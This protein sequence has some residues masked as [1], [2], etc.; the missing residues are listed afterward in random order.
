MISQ[1]GPEFE[2]LS[3]AGSPLSAGQLKFHPEARLRKHQKRLQRGQ[4]EQ[5]DGEEQECQEG[6]PGIHELSAAKA[7]HMGASPTDP[8]TLH[9]AALTGHSGIPTRKKRT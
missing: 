7:S 8:K 2:T 1:G 4:K 6:W 9:K 3:S 5:D